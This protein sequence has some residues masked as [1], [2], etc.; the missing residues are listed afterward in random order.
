MRTEVADARGGE[1]RVTGGMGGDIGPP[2][3]VPAA[4]QAL[5]T[6]PALRLILVGQEDVLCA[7]LA[8]HQASNHPHLTIHHATQVVSM[9]EAPAQALRVK[10]DSS[11]RVAINLVQQGVADACVSAGN[12]GALLATS[13]FVLKTLPGIDRPAICTTLPTVRGQGCQDPRTAPARLHGQSA[14]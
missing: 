13:R 7:A 4:L 6:S 1:D 5:R 12:T 2:V 8:Q 11:M 10:K 9:D 14:F 3:I